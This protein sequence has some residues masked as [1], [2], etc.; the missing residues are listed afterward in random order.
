MNDLFTVLDKVKELVSAKENSLKSQFLLIQDILNDMC[1][2][3]D[4][5]KQKQ[6]QILSEQV[7]L[8]CSCEENYRF[9]P[10]F[11][12]FCCILH[13]IFP[14]AYKFL[15]SSGNLILPHPRT[16][17][18]ICSSYTNGPHNEPNAGAML[19]YIKERFKSLQESDCTISLMMDEIHI[20]PYFDYKGGNIVGAA[21]DSDKAATTAYVFMI[22]SLLSSFKEVVHVLPV[23]NLV[24]EQL[25]LYVKKILCGLY[26]IGFK[27]I[28]VVSDNNAI[29]RKS[30][31]LCSSPPKLSIVYPH[32]T[33]PLFVIIDSVHILKCICNNWVN[34]KHSQVLLKYLQFDGSS[35]DCQVLMASF[36]ALRQLHKIECNGLLKHSYG[37]YLKSLYPYSLEKQNVSLVLQ[38]FNEYT[39]EAVSTVGEQ[40]NLLHYH[41]TAEFIKIILTWWKIVNVKTV[42]KG[43]RLNDLFQCPLS[44]SNNDEKLVFLEKF[45]VWLDKWKDLRLKN[46]TLSEDTHT[47]LTHTTYGLIE[48]ARYCTKELGFTY[49]LPGKIQTDSLEARFSSYRSMAG[50]QYLI[51]VR[52]IF[53][54]EAK[55]RMQNML[56]L[57]LN[58]STFA[59]LPVAEGFIFNCNDDT[60]ETI[61]TDS[62]FMVDIM[63]LEE[64]FRQAE[65]YIPILTYLAGYCVRNVLKKQQCEVCSKYLLLDKEMCLHGEQHLSLIKNLDRG[66]LFFPQPDVVN[67][68]IYNYITVQKLI[69]A[70]N[71]KN[72]CHPTVKGCLFK[73]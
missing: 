44:L 61:Q 9:N 2:S 56:P 66:G 18:K 28:C 12:V 11:S 50:S 29:N 15:R 4:E 40:K 65:T 14:H 51:S 48:M 41:T 34:Q 57:M 20:K 22:Q 72:F 64:D 43:V 62:E 67:D 53:E 19:L 37:L 60:K 10:H 32:P 47:A 6:I 21:F 59:K 23:R 13:S 39:A 25:F 27:V 58:S 69:S 54:V 42:H 7:K 55:M 45:L 26:Y 71:E 35:D 68:V 70:P 8:L 49:F 46:N 30:M 16:L 36:E 3:V 52:Q 1:S 33:K 63:Y 38:V 31:A 5:E 24:A 73:M 17:Q